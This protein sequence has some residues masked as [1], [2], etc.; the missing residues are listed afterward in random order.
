M[1]EST[2]LKN[3][4]TKFKLLDYNYNDINLLSFL[5]KEKKKIIIIINNKIN[6]EYVNDIFIETFA[7]TK[8]EALNK[9]ILTAISKQNEFQNFRIW[10]T[11]NEGE[12]W[13]GEIKVNTNH[14][15]ELYLNT[16][17][18]PISIKKNIQKIVILAE[19]ITSI[20]QSETEI[21]EK[22]K[23]KKILLNTLP[24]TIL[25]IDNKGKI[26]QS[27]IEPHHILFKNSSV[28][29]RN[30]CQTELPNDLSKKILN[31]V[32]FA[33]KSKKIKQFNYEI[34]NIDKHYECRIVALNDNE[35]VCILRD[36]SKRVL[37]EKILKNREKSYRSMVDNFPSGLLIHKNNKLYYANKTALKYLG[38]KNLNEL[39]RYCIF[40]LLRDE[41]KEI[42]RK[43]LLKALEGKNIPFMEF[44][45]MNIKT[46][47][48]FTYETKPV[49]F[50]YYGD[51]VCQIVMRDLSVQ[52]KLIEE[53]LRAEMAEK[54]NVELQIEM[55]KRKNTE[56]SLIH[57]LKEKEEL[58]KEIHHRVKNNMQVMTSILNLQANMLKDEET[59]LI[60]EESLNR[61]KSMALVHENI[62]ANKSLT[63]IDFEK[64]VKNLTQNLFRS[65]EINEKNVEIK[66]KIKN[67]Y[68]P[69]STAV[70]CGLI[71]NEIISYSIKRF[72]VEISK[73]FL[74]F[75]EAN[76]NNNEVQI[77]IS[78]NG[79]AIKE[80]NILKNPSH[81]GFQLVVALIDQLN[82]SI[83]LDSKN[84][85]KFS[86]FFNI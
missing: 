79:Q 20:K 84:T 30:I 40:D 5:I 58:I 65:Y 9:N 1:K 3:Y 78:D 21:I 33:I 74:I 42:A 70:P 51:K 81:L 16:S 76:L 26:Q 83:A 17:I 35:S 19:D 18:I 15:K 49:I 56:S 85:N 47:K 55:Q 77:N 13:N 69:V 50:D 80:K 45:I 12:N 4:L 86:I 82:G 59:K 31:A 68:L 54:V 32:K 60:F 72:F 24:D 28:N 6:I 11:I 63:N 37:A 41:H 46:K 29:E 57:S 14:K 8:E 67:F 23:R 7:I 61:I 10:K 27:K 73:S 66:Y 71:L 52:K 75:V 22:E 34:N 48:Y 25:I 53:T 36:I 44:P 62:Y 38:C 43:R 64:Y 2:E 39:R